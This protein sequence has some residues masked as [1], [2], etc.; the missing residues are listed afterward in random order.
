L[1][2]EF[3]KHIKRRAFG[4]RSSATGNILKPSKVQK[5]IHYIMWYVW[6]KLFLMKKNKGGIFMEIFYLLPS[7]KISQIPKFIF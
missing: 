2:S 1:N 6:G 5:Y 3:P 4:H 7:G